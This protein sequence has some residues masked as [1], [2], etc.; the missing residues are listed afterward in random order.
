MVYYYKGV[1]NAA[2]FTFASEL[3]AFSFSLAEVRVGQMPIYICFS[4]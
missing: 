4:I 3:E 1:D 2:I